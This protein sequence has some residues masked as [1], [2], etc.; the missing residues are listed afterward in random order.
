[1]ARTA[2]QLVRQEVIYNVSGLITTLAEGCA[3]VTHGR[4]QMKAICDL[5]EQAQELCSP[6]DDWE[7]TASQAGW[8]EAPDFGSQNIFRDK[9]DDQTWAAA[10]WEELCRD[11]DL[12]D[13]PIQREVFEHWVVSS[14]LAE[15]LIEKG[16]KVDRDFA[17]LTVW[18]R[19]TTGQAIAMDY[20]IQ[21][22]AAD[23]A[24]EYPE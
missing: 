4:D 22:I 19:T 10:N 6:I 18:A 23:L 21:S 8:E 15:K 20:V 5:A 11:H 16:E 9:N 3:A 24:R 12:D 7:E 2:D 17:G 1:M 14:W 13:D